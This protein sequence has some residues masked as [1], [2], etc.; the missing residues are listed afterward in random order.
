MRNGMI[1]KIS[2]AI[3]KSGIYVHKGVGR[4]HLISNPRE[5]KKFFDIPTDKNISEL[6]EIVAEASVNYVINNLKIK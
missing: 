2:Y 1:E 6:Q 3:P 5:A 4:G